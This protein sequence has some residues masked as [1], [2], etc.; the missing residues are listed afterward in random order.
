MKNV[1][2]VVTDSEGHVSWNDESESPECFATFKAAEKRARDMAQEAPG[3]A[4]HIYVLDATVVAPVS[5][6]TVRKVPR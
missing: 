1:N 6:P 2:F 5:H 4:V 3:K